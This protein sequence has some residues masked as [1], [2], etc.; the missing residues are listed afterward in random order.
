MRQR[1]QN[2]QPVQAGTL[3]EFSLRKLRALLLLLASDKS[4]EVV[5][6]AAAICRLLARHNLDLHHIAD[7]VT[8]APAAV[9]E[10]EPPPKP[11]DRPWAK[12]VLDLIKTHAECK[13]CVTEWERQFLANLASYPN[14]SPSAAQLDLLDKIAAKAGAFHAA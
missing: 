2:S 11:P 12:T 9:A 10:P 7:L 3:D 13:L 14:R 8:A 4:G 1:K 6:A 5:N